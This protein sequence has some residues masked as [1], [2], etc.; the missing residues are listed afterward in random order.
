MANLTQTLDQFFGSQPRSAVLASHGPE[1]FWV[2]L[3]TSETSP[4]LVLLPPF[5][6]SHSTPHPI[7]ILTKCVATTQSE[8]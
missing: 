8:L 1:P 6:V 4:D 7:S 2:Q 5:C 3:S